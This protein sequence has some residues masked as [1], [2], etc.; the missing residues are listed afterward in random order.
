MTP[1]QSFYDKDCKGYSQDIETAKKLAESSGLTGKTINYKFNSDRANMEAVATVVQQQLEKIGVKVNVQGADST[2]FF[3]SFFYM[4]YGS[5]EK[6]TSWDLASNGWDSERGTDL[7]QS[8]SYFN[9]SFGYSDEIKTLAQQINAT[10]D[11]DE[12]KTLAK[13]L[14]Q[15][16][17]DE[18]YQY[19]LTY[20]NY[21]MVS[22]KNVTGLDTCKIIPEFNDYLKISVK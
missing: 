8:L 19:P 16:T 15:K 22:K 14:Q 21:I 13:D 20:T 6:D 5:G 18:Y 4:W 7:G 17:L 10:V 2:T 11:Q 12:A 1:D 9:S 3:K